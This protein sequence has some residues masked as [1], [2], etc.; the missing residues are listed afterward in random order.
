MKNKKIFKGISLILII[1]FCFT[2]SSC[3]NS[4]EKDVSTSTTSTIENVDYKAINLQ[5][6]YENKNDE[7]IVYPYIIAIY[8]NQE[9]ENFYDENKENW[10][11]SNNAKNVD[12]NFRKLID[13]KYTEE[14]FNSNFLLVSMFKE[15][16]SETF[17]KIK[18]I[19]KSGEETTINV[20]KFLPTQR[21]GNESF[22]IIPIVVDLK[23]K[24]TGYYL[25]IEDFDELKK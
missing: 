8:N 2:L 19:E 18:S 10:D 9:L 7:K 11:L 5:V 17:H 12:K 1:I 16:D 4:S 23:Y 20:Q 6:N 3:N 25:K 13:E 14:F 22:W 15:T 24:G 21:D